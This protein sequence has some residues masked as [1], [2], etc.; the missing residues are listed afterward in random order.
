MGLQEL[1]KN[2]DT[3]IRFKFSLDKEKVEKM[4]QDTYRILRPNMKIKGFRCGRVPLRVA[5]KLNGIDKIY[6]PTLYDQLIS[7]LEKKDFDIY[8]TKDFKVNDDLSCE[9][10]VFPYQK[11]SFKQ[12]IKKL[13]I[14]SKK[15]EVTDEEI[16][17]SI[18]NIQYEFS[19]RVDVPED[20]GAQNGDEVVVELTVENVTTNTVIAKDQEAEIVIG[21]NDDGIGKHIVGVRKNEHG[22]FSINVKNE[23]YEYNV[24]CKQIWKLQPPEEKVLLESVKLPSM[25]VLKEK[26]KTKILE[27]K[28]LGEEKAAYTKLFVLLE[29]NS[30]FK[31][32]DKLVESLT[33]VINDENQ[34]ETFRNMV[35]KNY[36]QGSL[37]LSASK[38]LDIKVSD[39]EINNEII[40]MELTGK[41]KNRN[42]GKKGKL[43]LKQRLLERKVIDILIKKES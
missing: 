38:E 21:L 15:Q 6:G 33:S 43:D 2:E 28:Q 41:I 26:I 29:K 35:I 4:R 23:E 37:L 9:C 27:K 42:I 22:T 25:E 7:E 39:S 36:K 24:F 1:V 32:D 3:S 31:V 19:D 17:R 20:Y 10:I 18:K 5:E 11:V 16:N 14:A 30:D 8:A 12:D 34:K 40:K 13:E